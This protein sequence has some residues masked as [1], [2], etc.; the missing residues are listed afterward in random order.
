MLRLD[1]AVVVE[2]VAVQEQHVAPA[3]LPPSRLWHGVARRQMSRLPPQIPVQEEGVGVEHREGAV[4]SPRPGDQPRA[5]PSHQATQGLQGRLKA[6]GKGVVGV[7]RGVRRPGV[8]RLDGC[9]PSR[10]ESGLREEGEAP[11]QARGLIRG[12]AVLGQRVVD[13]PK[14]LFNPLRRGRELDALRANRQLH[15]LDHVAWGWG[16]RLGRLR[17][18]TKEGE[19]VGDGVVG[20]VR[21]VARV[22]AVEVV[23]EVAQEH[24]EEGAQEHLHG[25]RRSV[26][27][28]DA[29][30]CAEAHGEMEPERDARGG[31]KKGATMPGLSHRP[32]AI[33]VLEVV[34]ENHGVPAFR[35]GAQDEVDNV[36]QKVVRGDVGRPH[37]CGRSGASL[38][39]DAASAPHARRPGRWRRTGLRNSRRAVADEGPPCPRPRAGRP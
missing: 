39:R 8:Q 17:L 24:Q 35:P 11:S 2:D 15:P 12:E 22:D 7:S 9:P 38:R 6:H 1:D 36:P 20:G 27:V 37:R 19:E 4:N 14:D 16:L 32:L 21:R 29:R 34:A 23:D 3:I 30:G 5:V 26:K 33:G 10:P 18:E 28:P 25:V 31:G 13:V